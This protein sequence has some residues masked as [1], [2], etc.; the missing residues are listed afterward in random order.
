VRLRAKPVP[1]RHAFCPQSTYPYAWWGEGMATDIMQ[2]R[3]KSEEP[4]KP[5]FGETEAL[6]FYR[7]VLERLAAA[8]VPCLVGGAYA[9][10]YYTGIERDTK[11]LDIFL[12]RGDID[13]ALARLAAAGFHTELTHP[14]FLGKAYSG[15]RFVDLIFSSGNGM[16]PVDDEWFHHASE[17]ELLG[18]PIKF[19]S[20]EDMLW[21]KAFIMERERYD[22]GDV[23]H[24]LRASR[25]PLDWHRLVGRF[26]PHWRVLLAHLV[27]FG[28]IY[29]GERARI[30][31]HV[32][33]ELIDRLRSEPEW[34]FD[35]DLCQGSL[36]S[37]EQYLF[38]LEELSMKD[39]RL[40]PSGNMSAEE[41]AQ[42]TAAIE[43]RH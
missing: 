22:G 17:G 42:W 10:T 39:A 30:P 19:C 38:D 32:L 34:S 20:V 6:K 14:H 15:D 5:R 8:R 13:R 24:L 31:R 11:D 1:Q 7:E 23:V 25:A 12:R 9:L 36:L 3:L 27:L 43:N 4:T 33:D 28:F 21:Q 41:I 2:H 16:S 37:R 29:P 26:G 40:R 35:A 18:L